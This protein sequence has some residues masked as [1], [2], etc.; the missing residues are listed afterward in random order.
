MKQ[1]LI[2]NLTG[3]VIMAIGAGALLDVLNVITFW[4][5]FGSWWPLLF[6]VAGGFIA[7]G[8]W[9]RNYL[10]SLLLV[11]IGVA[12]TLRLNEVIDFNIG[13]LIVP[14]VLIFVGASFLINASHRSKVATGTNDTDDVSVIFSGSE[15]KNK[16]KDY[17]GGKVT[18]IFGGVVLDLRDAKITK[19]ATL[20]IVALCGGV[21]LRVP[22]EWR[23]VSKISPI[24]GGVE[25]KSEGSDDHKGPV[26]TL[27]GTVTL[28]GVE[29]KT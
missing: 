10:W 16:S 26:L 1:A 4:S 15:S 12:L 24:A 21:E 11:I 20:D 5:W 9:R 8:D 13:N 29:I 3:V 6:I 19:E 25:N 2:R 27:T 28:G 18:S 7:L 22:R 23:V 14:V 17:Q